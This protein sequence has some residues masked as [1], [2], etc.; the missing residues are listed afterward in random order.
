[1]NLSR[2]KVVINFFI[3]SQVKL[4]ACCLHEIIFVMCKYVYLNGKKL[5]A[6]QVVL[7]LT[8]H[9]QKGSYQPHFE[10]GLTSM[11]V[12]THVLQEW[13]NRSSSPSDRW[14][15]VL[16]HGARKPSDAISEVLKS[17]TFTRFTWIIGCF[18]TYIGNIC[19]TKVLLPPLPGTI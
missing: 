12:A 1:M 5:L 4:S 11:K 8:S 2:L 16:L 3:A 6:S 14:T 10:V 7:S 15:N 17:E 18:A 13:Q 19:L 9:E